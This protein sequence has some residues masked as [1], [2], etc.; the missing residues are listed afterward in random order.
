MS[1]P[2]AVDL[3]SLNA[4]LS[5]LNKTSMKAIRQK[6]LII[7]AYLEHLLLEDAP[8]TPADAPYSILTPSDPEARGAQLSI[9]FQPGLLPSIFSKL[10]NEGFVFDQRKP[11]VIRVAPAPLYNTYWE[12][13]SFVNRFKLALAE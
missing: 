7:T 11:D 12:V 13:W 8:S 3:A 2:S 9:K 5:I 4:G 6:S 1:N 10:S